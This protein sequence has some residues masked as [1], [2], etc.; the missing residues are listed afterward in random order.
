MWRLLMGIV[1]VWRSHYEEQLP[2]IRIM[3]FKLFK[4]TNKLSPGVFDV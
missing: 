3:T 2:Q 1:S 4:R